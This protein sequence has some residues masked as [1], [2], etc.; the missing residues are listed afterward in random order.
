M[1]LSLASRS[2][3]YKKL[4][5]HVPPLADVPNDYAVAIKNLP[6][7]LWSNP[8]NAVLSGSTALHML[9]TKRTGSMPDSWFPNDVDIYIEGSLGTL[10]SIIPDLY[11]AE[12][13]HYQGTRAAR[14]IANVCVSLTHPKVQFILLNT[15]VHA[16]DAVRAFDIEQCMVTWTPDNGVVHHCDKDPVLHP[17]LTLNTSMFNN[18]LTSPDCETTMAEWTRVITRVIKYLHRGF[19]M[20][21]D[22]MQAMLDAH[23]QAAKE[24]LERACM[25]S[26]HVQNQH[27]ERLSTWCCAE[28]TES[29]NDSQEH[30]F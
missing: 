27:L 23:A 16:E 18:P 10:M 22:Q 21:E 28:G 4:I 20:A 8:Y 3:A 6:S 2:Q 12:Y 11:L 29:N 25:V 30:S 1:L 17:H 13:S 5:T 15:D 9:H 14:Y 26:L 7:E 24:Q 19:I